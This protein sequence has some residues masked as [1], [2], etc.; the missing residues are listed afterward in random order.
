[1]IN[2]LSDTKDGKNRDTDLVLGFRTSLS[3]SL[4]ANKAINKLMM[5]VFVLSRWPVKN[6]VDNQDGGLEAGLAVPCSA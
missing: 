1:V 3:N 5:T 6:C 4:V 2:S